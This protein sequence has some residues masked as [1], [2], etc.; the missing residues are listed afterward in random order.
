MTLLS[1]S[2]RDT[3]G[4]TNA[5]TIG[6]RIQVDLTAASESPQETRL[7][8]QST[9]LFL[10]LVLIDTSMVRFKCFQTSWVKVLERTTQL[11]KK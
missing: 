11:R 8:T 7:Q 9:V 10:E 1:Q 5:E 6:H 4:I 2:H 3:S